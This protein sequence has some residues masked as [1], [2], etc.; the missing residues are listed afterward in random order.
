MPQQDS[1]DQKKLSIVNEINSSQP[2]LSPKGTIDEL[3]LP[4]IQLI[5]GHRDMVTTS[6]CSG[7]LSVFVEGSKRLQD[8]TRVS[9]KGEG[10]KWLFVTHNSSEV[11]GWLTSLIARHPEYKIKLVTDCPPDDSSNTVVRYILYKYESFILHVKC[12][13]FTTASQLYNIAMSCGFRESGIGSNHIVAI[14]TNINL[15]V[16]IGYLDEN[17]E[18]LRIFV[19]SDYIKFLDSLTLTK[20]EENTRKMNRLYGKIDQEIINAPVL[21]TKERETR[22]ERRER[23]RREGL[24]RQQQLRNVD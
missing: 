17:T 1:F 4:I 22:E 13:D 23:K 6:S 19:G 5:N 7:R 8:S 9:G 24:E 14:R 15:D 3:C 21:P 18:E 10:G 11:S 20:F 2:D 16:P 12:R